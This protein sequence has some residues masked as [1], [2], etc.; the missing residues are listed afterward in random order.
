MTT[1]TEAAVDLASTGR[2][3]ASPAEASQQV[4]RALIE[5]MSRPGRVQALA[6]QALSGMEPP[7]TGRG[8]TASL[9][10]LLDAE[11][12]VWLHPGLPV[13]AL[14]AYLRFHTGARLERQ[15]CDAGFVLVDTRQAGPGLWPTL[16]PSLDQGSDEAPQASATLVLELP[17]LSE[18]PPA[19][20]SQRL[21]LRGP[22]I[23]HSHTL[24][25]DGLGADFW[26]TR[27]ASA[28][29][30]PC[31]ID[32]ILCCGETI[33]AVPRTTHVTLEA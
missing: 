1:D 29:A 19:L 15:A 7:G 32:L 6:S 28:S 31:G 8:F 21:V 3:F 11:T 4:F 26:Q 17:V 23:A 5:A 25:L 10:S 24:Y 9:L 22:G 20:P 2:G 13:P 30:Y 16:W 18:Q 12:R 14:A 33:A 27:A